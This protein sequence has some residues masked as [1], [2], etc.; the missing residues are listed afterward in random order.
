MA[1]R[2]SSLEWILK[3][4]KD[5]VAEHGNPHF[6]IIDIG[7]VNSEEEETLYRG[8]GINLVFC[9]SSMTPGYVPRLSEVRTTFQNLNCISANT[10]Q[11]KLK[12][13]GFNGNE[14][15]FAGNMVLS[16]WASIH[17]PKPESLLTLPK[18]DDIQNTRT[19]TNVNL[20][21]Q[22]ENTIIIW[23]DLNERTLTNKSLMRYVL[24]TLLP[25]INPTTYPR[26]RPD[27]YEESEL[28]KMLNTMQRTR[29]ASLEEQLV[30]D[31]DNQAR[32]METYLQ[33]T[34][35][36]QDTNRSIA[37]QSQNT[38]VNED[39]AKQFLI[40]AKNHIKIEEWKIES[41]ILIIKL[42]DLKM[43]YKKE[44][45]SLPK[46]TVSINIRT[47]NFSA[48]ASEEECH[49]RPIHP[50]IFDEGRACLGN[51]S[52]IFPRIVATCQLAQVCELLIQFFEN[53]NPESPVPDGNWMIYR[54]CLKN[55]IAAREVVREE[56]MTDWHKYLT[57]T[58]QLEPTS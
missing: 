24:K 29:F 7:S 56:A 57:E 55:N 17:I 43:E 19:Y 48:I 25:R 1:L 21:Y 15:V 28:T 8:F 18:I 45:L 23:W 5:I 27:N 47:G 3:E 13:P 31:Q 37:I 30:R 9:S 58:N 46:I 4:N 54:W 44:V 11:F 40:Y 50:H 52:T 16:K 34:R 22:F 33:S 20:A 6:N 12:I 35:A 36:I 38:L 41:P 14:Y 2:Y 10:R 53:Y 51:F 26:N 32:A 39:L 42:K 49:M